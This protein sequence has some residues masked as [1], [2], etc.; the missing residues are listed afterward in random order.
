MNQ[1][2]D[3]LK[4]YYRYDY[5]PI[6]GI[7]VRIPT[8][9]EIIDYGEQQFWDM[10]Y[11]LCANT[12]SLRLML[13]NNGID[14]NDLTD[15]ELFYKILIP[16]LSKAKTQIILKD[17]DL[18]KLYPVTLNSEDDNETHVVLVYLNNTDI[19]IDECGYKKLIDYIRAVLDI[20]PKNE[21]AKNKVTKK[22]LIWED[23]ENIKI[24]KRKRRNQRW[25][26]SRLFPLISAALNHPGFKYKR[27]ELKE[28]GLIEFMDCI[29]RLH[30]YESATSLMTGM[31]MG[32]IDT[33]SIDLDKEL[34]WARD[35]YIT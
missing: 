28:I 22:S 7:S 26:T 16:L 15:F 1:S 17:F 3:I 2:F 35:M 24:D 34:N 27:E 8:I 21:F 9:G 33:K 18:S 6:D 5:S 29:K 23:E 13:W 32:M 10:A 19:Q 4:M 30:I 11:L 25:K 12:T 31:Y 20:H 14:W